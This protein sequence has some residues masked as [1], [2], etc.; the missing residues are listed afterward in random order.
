MQL[1][2]PQVIVRSVAVLTALLACSGLI[3]I[4]YYGSLAAVGHSSLHYRRF[5]AYG[6]FAIVPFMFIWASIQ[7]WRFV[8]KG[9]VSIYSGYL[10][11]GFMGFVASVL[12]W[13]WSRDTQDVVNGVISAAAFVIG[14]LVALQEKRFKKDVV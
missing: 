10:L 11:F 6:L 9:I 5:A 2:R 14:V 7:A 4:A 12:H 1:E 3:A 13:S 8:P